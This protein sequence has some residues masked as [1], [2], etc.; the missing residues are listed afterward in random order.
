MQCASN[1]DPQ[2][3]SYALLLDL[4][5]IHINA[6]KYRLRATTHL[7]GHGQAG[8]LLELSDLTCAPAEPNAALFLSRYLQARL[9]TPAKV[10]QLFSPARAR[11]SRSRLNEN[12]AARCGRA[13]LGYATLGA[14]AADGVA[15]FHI[16]IAGLPLSELLALSQLHAFGIDI[17]SAI[18]ALI[19]AG[20]CSTDL[21]QAD[22][23]LQIT[24]T[25]KNS[26]LRLCRTQPIALGMNSFLQTS[27]TQTERQLVLSKTLPTYLREKLS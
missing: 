6:I 10:T 26:A 18:N 14:P 12:H 1:P 7:S 17:A 24:L 20:L 4:L 22:C 11:T 8:G 9:G 25:S 19:Q 3:F 16:E 21:S 5:D 27:D 13:R 23:Q 2:I 15:R